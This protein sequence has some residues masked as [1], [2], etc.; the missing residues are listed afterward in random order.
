MQSLFRV[1]SHRSTLHTLRREGFNIT[2]ALVNR[3]CETEDRK[4]SRNSRTCS[5]ARNVRYQ[6]KRFSRCFNLLGASLAPSRS[7][8]ILMIRASANRGNYERN[9]G[10]ERAL[11][12]VSNDAPSTR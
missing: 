7:L 12:S 10:D 3:R 8:W 4:P 2:E 6:C 9:A 1:S 5:Q 11:Y